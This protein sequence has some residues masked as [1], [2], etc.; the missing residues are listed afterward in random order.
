[1]TPVVAVS[2]LV[3]DYPM[4]DHTVRALDGVDLAINPGEF[5]AVMGPS[6]SGKSTF[7]H[8]VGMLD[9]PTGGIYHFEG[10]EVSAL[11]TDDLPTRA[12][13]GSGSCFRPTTCCRERQQSKTS[14]FRWCTR[15]S[16]RSFGAPQ[17]SRRSASSASRTSQTINPISSRADNSSALQSRVRS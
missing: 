3:K 8:I 14:S 12:A 7:M 10:R 13:T 1:M 4:V 9:R 2:D 16:I 15:A 5:V 17:H 6:G 11:S